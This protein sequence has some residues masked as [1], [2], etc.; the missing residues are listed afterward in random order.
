MQKQQPATVDKESGRIQGM[1]GRIAGSYDRMNR[2]M[3]MRMDQGWRRRAAVLSGLRAG[4]SALDV[5]CGTGDLAL[6]LAR[7]MGHSGFVAATDFTQEML[8]LAAPKVAGNIIRLARADTLHLPFP[9]GAFDACS[10]GWGIRNV[11]DMAAGLREM[12]RV[13]K[14]G[15]RAVIL[16]STEPRN[17]V[18]APFFN[19]YFKRVMPAMGNWLSGSPD[20]AYSYL[21]KSVSEFPDAETFASRMR[22]AGFSSVT[23]E[24]HGLGAVAIHVGTK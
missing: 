20:K 17:P 9:D 12:R 23:Y 3:T 24:L 18:I 21:Q 2:L 4:D 8:E 7:R 15:G 10:V 16:E 14:P 11:A 5:C 22:E 19:F 6:A 1:F 13:L